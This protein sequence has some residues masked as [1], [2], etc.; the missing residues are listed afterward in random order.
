MHQHN[1]CSDCDNED[2]KLLCS[3]SLAERNEIR[4]LFERRNSLNEL[5]LI[6]PQEDPLLLAQVNDDLRATQLSYQQW[7]DTKSKEYGWV[8]DDCHHWEINF[9]SGDVLLVKNIV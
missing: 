7:W 6:I 4:F 3:V 8:Q 5:L 2:K 1:H 9:D